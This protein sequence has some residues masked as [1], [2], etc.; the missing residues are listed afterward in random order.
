M[1][2]TCLKQGSYSSSSYVLFCCL[3]MQA[4]TPLNLVHPIVDLDDDA[5][6]NRGKS[7]WKPGRH[8]FAASL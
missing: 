3:V 1:V 5:V 7:L 8:A 6:L 2:E 4:L